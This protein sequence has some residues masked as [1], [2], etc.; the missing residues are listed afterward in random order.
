MKKFVNLFSLIV[1]VSLSGSAFAQTGPV[2]YA[3]GQLPSA[4]APQTPSVP[5]PAI[6]SYDYRT[7]HL[8]DITAQC[9][10]N[11]EVVSAFP[12]IYKLVHTEENSRILKVF[13]FTDSKGLSR[14]IEVYFT[15]GDW[16]Q[17]GLTYIATNAGQKNG[18]VSAYFIDALSTPDHEDGAV[19]PR[20][21]PLDP[22]QLINFVA[23]EFLDA[24]GNVKAG[25]TS[26]AAASL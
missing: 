23:A 4:G 10:Q 26:A 20:I 21:N 8:Q 24:N 22:Q 13:S 16:M 1:L 17:Y 7:L 3:F 14:R 25:F 19:A 18:Q 11:Y 12:G 6:V 15:G 5:A 9:T 2:P